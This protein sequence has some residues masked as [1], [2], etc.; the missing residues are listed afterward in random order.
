D[1]TLDFGYNKPTTPGIQIVKTANKTAALPLEPVTYTYA[2]SNTG[3]VALENVVV[4]DDNGTPSYP[5]DDFNPAPVLGNGTTSANSTHNIGDRNNDGKLDPNEVW[6]YTATVIPVVN[7]CATVNGTNVNAGMLIIQ[8][9]TFVKSGNMVVFTV[10]PSMSN[11]NDSV[12]VT[13]LQS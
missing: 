9:G 12:K 5:A 1:L 10:D 3:G 6:Y 13:Y 2:V 7:E 4:V 11:P 8:F